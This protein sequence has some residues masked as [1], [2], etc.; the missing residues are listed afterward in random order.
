MM[1]QTAAL[2]RPGHSDSDA[3][4]ETSGADR[5]R[6]SGG[7]GHPAARLAHCRHRRYRCPNWPRWPEDRVGHK[8]DC[9]ASPFG[10]G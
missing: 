10:I 3:G 4:P 9:K 1:S 2:Y 6:R 8:V 7:H 5:P